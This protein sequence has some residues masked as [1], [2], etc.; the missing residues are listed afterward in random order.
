MFSR[1]P[2]RIHA[3]GDRRPGRAGAALVCLALAALVWLIPTPPDA[4]AATHVIPEIARATP[5]RGRVAFTFDGDWFGGR[6]ADI[7]AALARYDAR[8]TFFLTGHYL[9]TF[10]DNVRALVAADQQVASH[11]YEHSDYRALGNAGITER[12]THWVAAFHDLTGQY[13]PPFW[14]AP[15]GYSDARVRQAAAAAGD[16]TIYW[17]LDALDTVGNPKSAAFI[18]N[19][20]THPAINLDGAILLLHVN[21]DGTIDALPDVLATLHERGL[22]IV[23]VSDLLAP[24]VGR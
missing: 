9:N 8:A 10:P 6:I 3:P 7:V 5:G 15:Y 22:Q 13:G 18:F 2:N 4:A 19:R 23:T 24:P 17:T 1:Y 16:N 20:L 21:P 14:R 11:G 12:L